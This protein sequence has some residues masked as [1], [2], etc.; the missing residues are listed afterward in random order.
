MPTEVSS[1]KGL[2]L[3]NQ[4]GAGPRARDLSAPTDHPAVDRLARPRAD[5]GAKAAT[6]ADR[7]QPLRPRRRPRPPSAGRGD[8]AADLDR[9]IKPEQREVRPDAVVKRAS[10]AQPQ[11]RRA[12]PRNGGLGEFR[13]GVGRR[14]LAVLAC[15]AGF[16]LTPVKGRR[17]PSLKRPCRT[18]PSRRPSPSV[19]C[20][21]GPASNAGIGPP[22][23]P[24]P[25]LPRHPG[26]ECSLFEPPIRGSC[27][28][29]HAAWRRSRRAWGRASA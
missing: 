2:P 7:A 20:I 21:S 19:A 13:H 5:R 12:A 8:E 6:C 1:R 11:M 24:I 22:Q 25:T 23:P 29:R 18:L 3:G 16:E 26:R 28:G 4:A 9:R 27:R 17:A 14:G 10:V 15:P